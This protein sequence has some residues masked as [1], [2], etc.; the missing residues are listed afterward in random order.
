MK[1]IFMMFFAILLATVCLISCQNPESEVDGSVEQNSGNQEN[2]TRENASVQD[3]IRDYENVTTTDDGTFIGKDKL[4]TYQKNN[5]A[6]IRLENVSDKNYTVTIAGKYLDASGNEIKTETQTF[7][8]FAAG[9]SNYFMFKPDVTFS[10]FTYTLT[11]KEYVG[12]CKFSAQSQA[13]FG[14]IRETKMYNMDT[15]QQG[16]RKQYPTILA[17]F[18]YENCAD[19][20]MRNTL[21]LLDKNGEIYT[22]QTYGCSSGNQLECD[23]RLIMQTL[24]DT[25]IWPEELKGKVSGIVVVRLDE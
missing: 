14:Q 15:Y 3:P 9:W 5:I 22:M 24:E 16:D 12:E 8:G 11:T 21:I 18:Y 10:D 4:Y 23:N 13:Y 25:L 7:E 2:G 6:I 19:V 20:Q 17:D 1:R